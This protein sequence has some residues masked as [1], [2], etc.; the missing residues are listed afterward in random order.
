MDPMLKDVLAVPKMLRDR[1]PALSEEVRQVAKQIVSDYGNVPSN[2]I[3][4]GMGA[5]YFACYLPHYYLAEKGIKNDLFETSELLYYKIETMPDNCLLVCVTQSGETIEFKKLFPLLENKN[6]KIL[7]ITNNAKSTLQKYADYIINTNV[8]PDYSVAVK[9]YISA[10]FSLYTLTQTLIGEPALTEKGLVQMADYAEDMINK[11]DNFAKEA[12]RYINDKKF[13]FVTTARGSAIASALEASLL[14]R[15]GA[16]EPCIDVSGGQFRHGSVEMVSDK[17]FVINFAPD[18]HTSDLAL[19]L[20][21][22]LLDYKA[23]V[24]LITNKKPQFTHKRLWVVETTPPD[25][26]AA[27]I[28]DIIPCF[29]FTWCVANKKGVVTGEFV[30][31]VPVI[32]VE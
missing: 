1:C 20:T 19:S 6:V 29:L 30:N 11:R 26:Y 32:T 12:A 24:M 10:L 28:T 27:A 22:E 15:E 21:K 5:S 23:F 31:T 18:D 8:E 14:L 16:K 25:I 7:V 2:I 4:T 17:T 3:F 13:H 9:T